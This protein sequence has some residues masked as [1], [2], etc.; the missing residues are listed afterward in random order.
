MEINTLTTIQEHLKLESY[1]FI[2]IESL[3]KK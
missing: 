3:D 1:E 2:K